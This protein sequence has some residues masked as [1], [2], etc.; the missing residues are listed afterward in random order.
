MFGNYQSS[1]YISV[2]NKYNTTDSNVVAQMHND[3]INWIIGILSD[4]VPYYE[5]F[6]G[7]IP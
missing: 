1:E 4:S 6:I 3:Q 7:T 5:Q 2:E